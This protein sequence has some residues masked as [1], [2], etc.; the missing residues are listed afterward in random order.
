[1]NA[2]RGTMAS[3]V[4]MMS[5]ALM[6]TSGV[7]T[8]TAQIGGLGV[9][10]LGAAIAGADSAIGVTYAVAG[11]PGDVPVVFVPGTGNPGEKASL[12]VGQEYVVPYPAATPVTGDYPGSVVIGGNGAA[13]AARVS[14]PSDGVISGYSQGAHAA[15]LAAVQPGVA[16]DRTVTVVTIG[17]PC[18]EGTGVL[19]RWPVAQA[20]TGNVPCQPIPPGAQGIVINHAEDPIANFPVELNGLT[21]ANALAEYSYYHTY[22]Y[23]PV[24][25]SRQDVKVETVGNVTYVTIPRDQTPALVRLA[26]DHGIP[27]SP[28]VERWVADATYRPDPGPL[29]ASS[30]PPPA[31][32]VYEAAAPISEPLAPAPPDPVTQA[33]EVVSETWQTQVVEP[34]VQQTEDWANTWTAPVVAPAPVMEPSGNV[35]AVADSVQAVL[36]PDL[37]PVVDQVAADV[38]N[39]PLGGFLN[40]LPRL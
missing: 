24:D 8:G 11:A 33:V 31:M 22:G 9:N 2:R 26:R 6:L 23:G 12:Y 15:R 25:M 32:P 21:I 5:A 19:V 14:P 34:F 10:P 7:L 37:A 40:G 28:E 20:A 1:M 38:Q 18:T 39:S 36:P 3:L 17:D 16:A 27:V 13:E 30:P 4:T 29:G 35:A